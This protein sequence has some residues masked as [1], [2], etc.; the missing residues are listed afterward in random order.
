MQPRHTFCMLGAMPGEYACMWGPN[1]KTKFFVVVLAGLIDQDKIDTAQ[2][3]WRGPHHL[4]VWPKP[5][6]AQGAVPGINPDVLDA[7]HFG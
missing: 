4:A 6:E 2:S 5:L 7:I 1:A 3:R